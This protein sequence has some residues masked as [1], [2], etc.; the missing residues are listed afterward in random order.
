MDVHHFDGCSHKGHADNDRRAWPA[1]LEVTLD[2][3]GLLHRV[4]R[5]HP[6]KIK[7][8]QRRP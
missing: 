6:G 2:R 1:R 5:K 7:T 8:G 4:Q 3:E